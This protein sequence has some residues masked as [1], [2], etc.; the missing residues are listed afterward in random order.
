MSFGHKFSHRSVRLRTQLL[1]LP[2]GRMK[3]PAVP[4]ILPSQV[5][6]FIRTRS[7]FVTDN[8]QHVRP[9]NRVGH[10]RFQILS[11]RVPPCVLRSGQIITPVK[12][13]RF[14]SDC[15]SQI[16]VR[17]GEVELFHILEVF[18]SSLCMFSYQLKSLARLKRHLTLMQLPRGITV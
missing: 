2:F 11:P 3:V 18:H 8:I 6:S 1:T 9:T 12:L 16:S 13:S 17:I 15:L 4:C 7:A 5:E 14:S 10:Q